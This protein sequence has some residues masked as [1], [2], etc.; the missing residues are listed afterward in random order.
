MSNDH[1]RISRFLSLV[2]RHKPDA[3]D[4]ALDAHGW[5]D[6]DALIRLANAHGRRL[7]RSVLEHVV[8]ANDKQRFAFSP[9]GL[10]IRASQ[11]HSVDVDLA[12][13]PQEPPATLYHGTAERFV[14]SIRAHGLRP[15][16][17]NHVHLSAD[18]VTARKVGQR[19]GT[20]VIL[21]VRA[22]AMSAAGLKFYRSA[23]GVWLTEGVPIEYIVFPAV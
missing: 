13:S 8:A 7:N 19:H 11:G 22:Q 6:V 9:D 3:I 2:L 5:A 16:S 23:N 21:E 18:V 14:A 10:R 17:R 4:L 12:L 20:P 15:G 1:V